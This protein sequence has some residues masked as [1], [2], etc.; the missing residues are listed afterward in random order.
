MHARDRVGWASLG[1]DSTSV[2]RG[3][4]VVCRVYYSWVA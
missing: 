2:K 3:V 4:V 1:G